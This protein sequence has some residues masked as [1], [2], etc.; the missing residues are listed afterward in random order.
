MVFPS[1]NTDAPAG[2]YHSP[3]TNNATLFPY[4]S[5]PAA[6]ASGGGSGR[7]TIWVATFVAD[8]SAIA[9]IAK[10]PRVHS[11]LIRSERIN[12]RATDG[13]GPNDSINPAHRL[14]EPAGNAHITPF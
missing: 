11:R 5:V 4:H 14:L 10:T 7:L 9:A 13:A 12:L 3:P 8:K 1:K 2:S 6:V